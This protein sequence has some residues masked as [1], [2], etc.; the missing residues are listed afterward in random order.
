[1]G[2]RITKQQVKQFCDTLNLHT[3]EAYG[4]SFG[5]FGKV[6]LVDYVGSAEVDV[7]TNGHVSKRE[8]INRMGAYM[9]GWR[10]CR[11]KEVVNKCSASTFD[12]PYF[13]GGVRY[14][15]KNTAFVNEGG[16]A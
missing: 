16:A 13:R 11:T 12:M 15:C 7:L 8:L 9:A 1:M 14:Q 4:I 3:G 2:T 10:N 6:S 5:S